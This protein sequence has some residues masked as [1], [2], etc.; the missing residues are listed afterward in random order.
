MRI[1]AWAV[2]VFATWS[3]RLARVRF[4][5]AGLPGWGAISTQ[6]TGRLMWIRR[7]GAPSVLRQR[8]RPLLFSGGFCSTVR[9]W[10]KCT[11]T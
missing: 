8:S 3:V 1:C 6:D 10:V 5:H 11:L 4:G 2:F 9:L 7:L